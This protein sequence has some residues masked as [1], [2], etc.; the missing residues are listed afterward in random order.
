[1]K[2]GTSIIALFFLTIPTIAQA[3]KPDQSYI[4]LSFFEDRIDGRVEI[5]LS[6]LNRALNLDFKTDL[7]AT[8]TQLDERIEAIKSYVLQRVKLKPNG[9]A[10]P[11]R[12]R[13]HR[14]FS[15]SF[16][17]YAIVEFSINNL[18]QM[19][20]KVDVEFNL[21]F[22]INPDHRGLLVIE[23]NWKTSTFNSETNVALTFD[24]SNRIQQ[25]DLSESTL[26][27][28]FLGM[29]GLG[30]HHIAIG[31]DHILFIIALLLP[32]VLRRENR[33]WLPE[34]SFRNAVIQ[35]IKIVTVFTIAHTITLS[36][37]TLG[38]VQLPSR[39]VESVIA[40]SIIL[41]ALNIWIPLF[42]GKI[43]WVVF[44][45]GLFHGFGFADVLASMGIQSSYLGLSLLGFNLGVEVGQLLVVCC[46]FPLL[47]LIRRQS[48]YIGLILP[49]GAAMLILV[50]GYWF[51]ERAF[52]IDLPAGEYLNN[53]IAFARNT[54]D[55]F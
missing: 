49:L 34:E 2:T 32:S 27:R 10:L 31:I 52:L 4:F 5:P 28:G 9:I 8:E 54:I 43:W 39:L 18:E 37:A 24:P 17:Q 12:I 13:G 25:L 42:G 51:I 53:L 11:L 48:F 20:D 23:N 3:H 38:A 55:G 35:V 47:Y 50:A 15:V 16:S 7:N 22:D 30:T 44:G 46:A 14:L 19:P 6:D 33:H 40:A 21:M 1:M 45:F 36:L 26:W 41:V 29:I